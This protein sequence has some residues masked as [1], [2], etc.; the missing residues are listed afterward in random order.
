MSDGAEVMRGIERRP[1][2]TYSAL[3]PNLVGFEAAVSA[4]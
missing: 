2:V 3:T 1:G 4:N